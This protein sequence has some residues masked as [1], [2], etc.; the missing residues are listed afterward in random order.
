MRAIFL[1]TYAIDESADS[2]AY[3]VSRRDLSSDDYSAKQR[4]DD[5]ELIRV[6]STSTGERIDLT[7]EATAIEQQVLGDLIECMRYERDDWSDF[8]FEYDT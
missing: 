6:T 1:C 7:G 8:I 4:A 2:T 5:V 3:I